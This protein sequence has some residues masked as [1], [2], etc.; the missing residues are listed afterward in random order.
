MKAMRAGDLDAIRAVLDH[1][2]IKPEWLTQALSSVTSPA[3]RNDEIA[4]LL[5]N[6]G[7]K[8]AS[9]N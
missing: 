1:G 3:N 8:A 5:R 7:A 4:E 9:S 2:G 6:A